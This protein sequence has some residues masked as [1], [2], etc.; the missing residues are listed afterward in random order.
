MRDSMLFA[1]VLSLGA[2]GCN[3]MQ[4]LVGK[5]ASSES[6]AAVT[7]PAGE[8]GDATAGGD[9]KEKAKSCPVVAEGEDDSS[10][11]GDAEADKKAAKDKDK[12]KSG[13]YETTGL[14]HDD[15]EHESIDCVSEEGKDDSYQG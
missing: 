11:S 2:M 4:G 8:S 1:L 9:D 12:E 7:A 14:T 6:S 15:M 3:S 13:E 10:G 5:K